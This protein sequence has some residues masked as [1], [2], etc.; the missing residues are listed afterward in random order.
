MLLGVLIFWWEGSCE[1]DD[2]DLYPG[3]VFMNGGIL[4]CK[5]GER[6]ILVE[7]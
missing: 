2:C 7:N 5:K 4:I 3:F 1:T 6:V